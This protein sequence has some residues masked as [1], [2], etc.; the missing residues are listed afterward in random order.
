[1]NPV[2]GRVADLVRP[3]TLM[4]GGIV[5]WSLAALGTAT[6]RSVAEFLCWRA[7]M[8]VTEAVFVPAAL[9]AIGKAHPGPTRSRALSIYST[10]QMVGIVIGGWFGGW[11]VPVVGWRGGYVI[12]A[13]IGVAFAPA[14]RKLIGSIEGQ[15]ARRVRATRP[16]AVLE[17]RSY[18]ALGAGF[19][20][21]C[22]MLWMFYAWL[23]ETVHR[24]YGLT[25]AASG[26]VA[27]APTQAGSVAGLLLGGYLADRLA[28]AIP[29]ARFYLSA[30]G[31]ALAAPFAVLTFNGPDL[32]LLRVYAALFGFFSALMAGNVFA[33]AYDVT[34]SSRYGIASGALNMV[35]GLAGGA[36]MFAAGFWS[37]LGPQGLMRYTALAAI[38]AGVTLMVV[39]RRTFHRDRLRAGLQESAPHP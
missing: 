29:Q 12:L 17:S 22:A 2:A 20:L 8:G 5:M 3:E 35:G 18:L 31:L 13:C 30:L 34:P 6:S 38:L 23:P 39:A 24:R 19:L 25:L 10:G 16:L 27:T 1:M 4:T 9:S 21:L 14:F 15:G 32:A 37:Q 11:M 26:L 33:A 36:A 28:P 7:A